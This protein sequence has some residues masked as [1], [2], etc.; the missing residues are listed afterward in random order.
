MAFSFLFFLV[1][2]ESFV[3]GRIL[4]TT[5]VFFFSHFKMSSDFLVF[6]LFVLEEFSCL[7]LIRYTGCSFATVQK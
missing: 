7:S 1:R 5:V 4:I 2:S 3:A 6:S